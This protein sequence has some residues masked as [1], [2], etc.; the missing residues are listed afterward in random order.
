MRLLA[1][2]QPPCHWPTFLR[3]SPLAGG[4]KAKMQSKLNKETG[5]EEKHP[6]CKTVEEHQSI[7]PAGH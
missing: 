2:F 1:L 4:G 3:G 6:T 5:E 7:L